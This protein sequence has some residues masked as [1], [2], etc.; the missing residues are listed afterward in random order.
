MDWAVSS[1]NYLRKFVVLM[2]FTGLMIFGLARVDASESSTQNLTSGLATLDGHVIEYFSQGEG[3]VVILLTGRTLQAGYLEPLA[4]E[5][6][7]N[8]FR[9]IIINRRGAGRS[10][11]SLQDV[12]YHTH[13]ADAR[14]LLVSLGISQV[15]VL[16]HALGGRIARTMAADFPD[17]VTKVILL[18]V[19]DNGETDPE[20][21]KATAKLFKPDAT[22]TEIRAGMAYMVGNPDDIDRV[23]KTLEPSR[24]TNP[25]AIR[26][27]A[28]ISTPRN[29]W[30]APDGP[31]PYLVVQGLEDKSA[32]P[33]NAT[34]FMQDMKG[35]ATRVDL[36]GIGHLSPIEAPEDV[37]KIIASFLTT[38]P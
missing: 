22:D 9:A 34:R 13:A 1:M 17:M 3:D 31:M 27:E 24:Y 35:R 32:L 38:S 33:A 2:M 25:D 21:A 37:A 28:H 20:E 15:S 4:Q 36:P 19:G 12:D 18:A 7:E 14:A 26:S 11:G 6:A 5:I 8:G 23:W 16:G 10:T 30:W 29:D